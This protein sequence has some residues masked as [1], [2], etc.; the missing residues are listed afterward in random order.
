MGA[1]FLPPPSGPE[2][3]SVEASY[4]KPVAATGRRAAYG[5]RSQGKRREQLPDAP[6]KGAICVYD[7]PPF[8][9]GSLGKLALKTSR[10]TQITQ[11]KNRRDVPLILP[12]HLLFFA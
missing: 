9:A 6:D 5:L 4:G 10:C 1:S 11:T 3:C 12:S 7:A 2:H 8:P